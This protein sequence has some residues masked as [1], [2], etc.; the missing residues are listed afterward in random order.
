MFIVAM[1]L[2]VIAAM[3]MYA[4]NVAGTEVK[5]AGYVREQTQA[6]Y[7]SEYGVLSIAQEISAANAYMYYRRAMY[8]PDT[9]CTSLYGTPATAVGLPLACLR[10]GSV[11]VAKYWTPP[12]VT[13]AGKLID[14][15]TGNA[16]ENARGTGG[17]ATV[18]DFY[19]EI[20]DPFSTRAPAGYGSSGGPSQCFVDFTVAAVG[21]TPLTAGSYL[22][23]G[24]QTSRARIVAGPGPCP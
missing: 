23:E 7:L 10:I 13:A 19:V 18:P 20:T 4:L 15:Y 16:T 9:N 2:A 1:T 12:P 3:G 17:I 22:S 5:T 21:M 24:L 6:Y 11:E 14:A 8:T